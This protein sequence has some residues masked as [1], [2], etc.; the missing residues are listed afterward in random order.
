MRKHQS[1]KKVEEELE[2]KSMSLILDRPCI[3]NYSK[4]KSNINESAFNRLYQ[5]CK[6]KTDKKYETNTFVPSID[7]S[8]KKII[9][10]ER[11]DKILYDDAIKR[12]NKDQNDLNEINKKEPESKSSKQYKLAEKKLE[13]DF[14]VIIENN[15]NNLNSEIINTEDFKT[16]LE[17]LGFM[18]KINSDKEKCLFD[19]L[20]DYIK[21]EDSNI[22]KKVALLALKAIMNFDITDI[23]I[24]NYEKNQT[25]RLKNLRL[26][27]HFYK[28]FI[29]KLS[30]AMKNSKIVEIKLNLEQ[31]N[32]QPILLENSKKLSKINRDQLLGNCSNIDSDKE[33]KESL[34]SPD[35]V[36]LQKEIQY[37]QK[38][39]SNVIDSIRQRSK[40]Q[41]IKKQTEITKR[42]VE[43]ECTFKPKINERP[44]SNINIQRKENYPSSNSSKINPISMNSIIQKK[45]G[46]ELDN[47]NL[48]DCTFKP[49]INGYTKLSKNGPK[50][51][52]RKVESVV[53]RM[54]KARKEKE[55]IIN[56]LM[57]LQGQTILFTEVASLKFKSAFKDQKSFNQ[58]TRVRK[59]EKLAE[60]KLNNTLSL[61][62]LKDENVSF[63]QKSTSQASMNN[64]EEKEPLLC[65]DVNLEKGKVDQIVYYEGDSSEKLAKDFSFKNG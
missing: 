56:K 60:Q 20:I 13:R 30:N 15:L 37:I 5:N 26:H 41:K 28:F 45:L 38:I 52:P 29:N 46:I 48:K 62:R 51:I 55:R 63:L 61:V 8:S 25:E 3:N 23:S 4:R 22:E 17:E 58:K 19:K 11:I 49:I 16:L 34:S 44:R 33:I 21:N 59:V 12:Q 27:K 40:E 50:I 2:R 54:Q 18:N 64:N 35:Q 1:I 24:S 7:E 57:R 65:I 32:H 31:S 36:P 53:Q 47:N 42:Q 9:R 6:N 43:K 14:N 39:D 10:K